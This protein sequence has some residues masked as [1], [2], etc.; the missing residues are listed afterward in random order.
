MSRSRDSVRERHFRRTVSEYA[1]T[2][3]PYVVYGALITSAQKV[4]QFAEQMVEWRRENRMDH[5]LKWERAS[6]KLAE[7]KRFVDLFFDGNLV[8]KGRRMTFSAVVFDTQEI[9]RIERSKPRREAPEVGFYKRYYH[10]LLNEFGK[11]A[12]D[13]THRLYVFMDE[14]STRYGMP[15]F[16]KVLDDGIVNKYSL[17]LRKVVRCVQPQK[18]HH[19]DLLQMADVLMGAVGW[20]FN[21]LGER[22]EANPAK[23]ALAAYVA[24]RAGLKTLGQRARGW[25]FTIWVWRSTQRPTA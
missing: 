21:R 17:N 9:T 5:E 7:Y 15:E 12:R 2:A 11:R 25:Q 23:S 1:A 24:E 19:S 3:H 8:R 13:E 20:Q 6:G 18:S 16:R 4:G 14:G 10:F 22:P